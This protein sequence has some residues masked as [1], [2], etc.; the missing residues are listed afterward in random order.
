MASSNQYDPAD[1]LGIYHNEYRSK[2][3]AMAISN[4]TRYFEL[5]T[6]ILEKIERDTIRTIYESFYQLMVNGKDFE[7]NVLLDPAPRYPS[8]KANKFCMSA[9]ET[10]RELTDKCL[11]KIIPADFKSLA[12]DRLE[13]SA[14]ART[15]DM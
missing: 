10:L 2:M 11:A 3:Y 8:D 1:I 12:R 9:S 14:N 13:E 7:G 4:P 6:K 5:H 15:I